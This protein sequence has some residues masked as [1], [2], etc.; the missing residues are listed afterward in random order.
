[1]MAKLTDLPAEITALIVKLFVVALKKNRDTDIFRL[2]RASRVFRDAV[3]IA[4]FQENIL[5]WPADLLERRARHMVQLEIRAYRDIE[6]NRIQ[7][8]E[9]LLKQQNRLVPFSSGSSRY[10][11]EMARCENERQARKKAI[12]RK[13]KVFSELLQSAKEDQR[14]FP[15]IVPKIDLKELKAVVRKMDCKRR[16]HNHDND[17]PINRPPQSYRDFLLAR[18]WAQMHRNEP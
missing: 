18:R 13:L 17:P 15:V 3:L 6:V 14:R 5:R 8:E 9:S 16:G 2:M 12:E 4:W 10:P 11:P 1:M 7:R